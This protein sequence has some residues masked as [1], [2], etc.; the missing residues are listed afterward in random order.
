M[1]AW[2]YSRNRNGCNRRCACCACNGSWNC[3]DYCRLVYGSSIFSDRNCEE[4][5]E[6]FMQG[7]NTANEVLERLAADKGSIWKE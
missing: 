6:I 7:Y 5:E 1:C 4:A 2:N 3:H